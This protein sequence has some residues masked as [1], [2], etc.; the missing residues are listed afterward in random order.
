MLLDD[1]SVQM[2]KSNLV[3]Q[4]NHVKITKLDK[5]Q[6]NGQRPPII[7]KLNRENNV[8]NLNQSI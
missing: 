2:A 4:S 1:F 6:N 8:S 5:D 7:V 3:D